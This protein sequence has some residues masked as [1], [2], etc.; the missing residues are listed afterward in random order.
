MEVPTR[1]MEAGVPRKK[2]PVAGSSL[3]NRCARPVGTGVP[4]GVGQT[5]WLHT[6]GPEG[7]RIHDTVA[8]VAAGSPDNSRPGP[9]VAELSPVG[10]RGLGGGA[11][12]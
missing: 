6:E 3:H 9:P 4:Q 1:N 2:A 10:N 11:E 7:L 5:G 12:T 8:V